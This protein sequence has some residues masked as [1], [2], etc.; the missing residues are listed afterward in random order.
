MKNLSLK[1]DLRV[2]PN[3]FLWLQGEAARLSAKANEQT[4]VIA[5]LEGQ[6]S[7]QSLSLEQLRGTAQQ[8]AQSASDQKQQIMDLQATLSAR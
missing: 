6:L 4:S 3:L 1:I 7:D 8:Q 5:R 2:F